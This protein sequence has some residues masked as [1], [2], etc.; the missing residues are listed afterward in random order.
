MTN[1]HEITDSER[2]EIWK[3]IAEIRQYDSNPEQ[4]KKLLAAWKQD[5]GP[6]YDELV[7]EILAENVCKNARNWAK[8]KGIS[9]AEEI[10]QNMWE[11]WDEGEF[12]IERTE[13]GIQIHCTGCPI[14]DAYRSIGEIELGVLFQCNEDPHIVRGINPGMA[15]RRTK[16]LMEGD[17]CCDHY[18]PKD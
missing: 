17:D 5:Y 2:D 3:R 8:E 14:A 1:P 6:E 10:V 13:S 11:G 12:T 9:T 15:F 4:L 7:R 18:Y 16:T